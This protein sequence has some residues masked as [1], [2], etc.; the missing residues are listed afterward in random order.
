MCLWP[1]CEY[2]LTGQYEFQ[3]ECPH[4]LAWS[5]TSFL[6]RMVSGLGEEMLGVCL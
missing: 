5:F 2:Y 3:T 4:L 6:F 1:V